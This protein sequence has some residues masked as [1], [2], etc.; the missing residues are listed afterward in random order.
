MFERSITSVQRS[1]PAGFIDRQ[2]GFTESTPSGGHDDECLAK[3]GDFDGAAFGQ[4]PS[5]GVQEARSQVNRR[6]GS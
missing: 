1:V 2:D 5:A 6:I 3:I 4:V